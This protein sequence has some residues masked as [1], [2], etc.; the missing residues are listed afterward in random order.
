MGFLLALKINRTEMIIRI[1]NMVR[2]IILLILYILSKH[3]LIYKN[4][5]CI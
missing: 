4:K 5:E 3:F 1:D 2:K